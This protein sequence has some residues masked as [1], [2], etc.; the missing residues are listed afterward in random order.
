MNPNKVLHPEHFSDSTRF[1]EEQL[2]PL[3]KAID[4]QASLGFGRGIFFMLLCFGVGILLSTVVKGTIG[5]TLSVFAYIAAP[6]ALGLSTAAAAK[7]VKNECEKLG[8]S[9]EE[10]KAAL[11]NR[12]NNQVVNEQGQIVA[13]NM[14]L[15]ADATVWY[16]FTCS[17]CGKD[18]GWKNYTLSAKDRDNLLIK[19]EEFKKLTG[20]KKRYFENKNG[21]CTYSL[22]NVC[23]HCGSKQ[24]KKKMSLLWPLLSLIPGLFGASIFIAFIAAA[25]DGFGVG[26]PI[27]A[28]LLGIIGI[29][30]CIIAFILFFRSIAKSKSPEYR[31][32][33]PNQNS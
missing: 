25:V 30:P 13:Q 29:A 5:Y 28:V 10:F 32:D 12:K 27:G 9:Q 16:R 15:G 8:I 6:A 24:I 31:F 26:M 23:P 21:F 18:S 22:D 3:N 7:R 33:D 17:K 2:E 19:T 4:E 11:N 20:K 14:S 1:T